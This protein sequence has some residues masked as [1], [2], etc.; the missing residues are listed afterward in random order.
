MSEGSG[1]LAAGRE[2]KKVVSLTRHNGAD[3][4]EDAEEDVAGQRAEPVDDLS[5][6]DGE[7]DPKH[8]RSRQRHTVQE[9]FPRL[10]A[11]SS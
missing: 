8:L 1:Q 4:E 5:L 10:N 9:T 11:H 6:G 7:D 3:D 2:Q